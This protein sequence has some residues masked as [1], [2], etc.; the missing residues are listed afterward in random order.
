MRR[1][2][3][4]DDE[5][6]D[7]EMAIVAV[8]TRLVFS[9]VEGFGLAEMRVVEALRGADDKLIGASHGE[10]GDYLRTLGTGEL[11]RLVAAIRHRLQD[12]PLRGPGENKHSRRAR[13]PSR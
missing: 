2:A 9:D 13:A 3:G 1:Q 11:T 8:F 12:G 4:D 6:V 5:G 7:T 10:V